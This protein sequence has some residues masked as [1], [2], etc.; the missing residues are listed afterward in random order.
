MIGKPFIPI[1]LL[2]LVMSVFWAG[3]TEAR[4]NRAIE[5]CR[6]LIQQGDIEG[7]RKK[8]ADYRHSNPGDPYGVILLARIETDIEKSA[9]LY[10]EAEILAI[11][12]NSADRDSSLAAEALY[13]RAEIVFA[14]SEPG[15]AAR[16][17]ERL[18]SLFP[19]SDYFYDAVYRLGVINCIQGE[20]R[21]ALEKFRTCREK[22]GD[23]SKKAL[24]AAGIMEC[25]VM[26][27][28]WNEA[29]AAARQALDDDD[30]NAAVTPRVLE[31]SAMVWRELGNEQNAAWYTDRLLKSFPDSYQAHAIRA[32]AGDFAGDTG[33]DSAEVAG[34]AALGSAKANTAV[35]DAPIAADNATVTGQASSAGRFTIQAGAFRDRSNARKLYDKLKAARY[36]ARIEMKDVGGTHFFK[37]LVGVYATE[38]EAGV[39]LSGVMKASGERASVIIIE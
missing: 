26:M 36:D 8:L 30:E 7:A 39:A 31:V 17:Y 16:L 29:L 23:E 38:A 11:G 24:A 20:P 6:K 22:C 21:K 13:R 33:S 25:F 27:K 12:P 15:E 3:V 28:E 34:N 4:D 14:G 37:V 9:A 35:S 19:D 2:I 10:R 5:N 32:Q 1:I 18:V